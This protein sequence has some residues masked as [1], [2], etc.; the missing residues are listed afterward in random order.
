MRMDFS[1]APLIF[2]TKFD[3]TEA[4][5]RKY[6]PDLKKDEEL[7]RLSI[8]QAADKC[9]FTSQKKE[10]ALEALRAANEEFN[11]ISDEEDR[12]FGPGADELTGQSYWGSPENKE[13][14]VSYLE[15][16][17]AGRKGEIIFYGPSNITLWFSLERDME[18]WK[19]QNHGM[20][21]CT[22]EDMIHY[23]DRLLYPFEPK[24][25]FFQTGSNDLAM[26]FTLDQ[27]LANKQKMYTEFLEKMPQAHL[28]VMSGLPLP[29]RMEFWEAT[30]KTNYHLEKMCGQYDRLHFMNASDVM[31]SETGEE[32]FRYKDGKYFR[33]ELYREDRIHL[34]VKGHE[35]WTALQ[36]QMLKDL[37]I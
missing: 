15:Q 8:D 21:G 17:Y 3:L 33:P 37:G 9:G 4:V 24:A 34:N 18:P 19:A 16:K 14:C 5:V 29:G 7:S 2:L 6:F 10:E 27:V 20:G 30:E 26:G 31:M 12:E 36:K 13:I 1:R 32:R 35:V 11:R 28:I 25:V 22:D 23:A